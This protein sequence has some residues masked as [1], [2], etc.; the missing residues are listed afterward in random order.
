MIGNSKIISY[1]EAERDV[2]N[3]WMDY[4]QSGKSDLICSQL[5]ISIDEEMGEDKFE[6]WIGDYYQ[7]G[8]PIPDGFLTKVIP[9][10][11]WAIFS[12]KGESATALPRLHQ[13]IFTEW[14]PNCRD[15]EIADGYHIEQYDDP[16]DYPNGVQDEHYHCEIWIPIKQK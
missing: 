14:L 12:C 1:E 16:K 5:G 13:Q 3:F 8:T 7:P 9:A 15:Y 6:Y 10:H 11:T 4:V 2:P